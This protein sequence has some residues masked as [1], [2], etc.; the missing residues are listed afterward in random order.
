VSAMRVPVS[1][2]GYPTTSV[3]GADGGRLILSG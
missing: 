2:V 1:L 3:L